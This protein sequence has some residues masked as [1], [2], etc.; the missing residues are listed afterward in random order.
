M[1]ETKGDEFDMKYYL[2]GE[3]WGK[4]LTFGYDF[5]REGSEHTIEL[6]CS[7][8]SSK[9]VMNDPIQICLITGHKIKLSDKTDL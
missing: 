4:L 3:W 6:R 7:Q 5:C 9:D 2:K 1:K 8:N